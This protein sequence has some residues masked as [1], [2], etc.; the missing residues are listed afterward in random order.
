MC[1]FLP[2]LHHFPIKNLHAGIT[3]HPTEL[4]VRMP[5]CVS[6]S[7]QCYQVLTGQWVPQL[8]RVKIVTPSHISAVLHTCDSERTCGVHREQEP[9]AKVIHAGGGHEGEGNEAVRKGR[10]ER[11]TQGK[12]NTLTQMGETW[13]KPNTISLKKK[14]YIF[15]ISFSKNWCFIS[16]SL[17][18]HT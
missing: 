1:K 6:A 3:H 2:P 4:C 17:I 14:K 12:T 16:A 18:I 15:L 13:D 9:G 10:S 5:G 11:I 8:V 7:S